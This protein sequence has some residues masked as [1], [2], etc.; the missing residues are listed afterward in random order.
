[1]CCRCEERSPAIWCLSDAVR[2][3]GESVDRDCTVCLEIRRTAVVKD[4]L[5]EARKSKFNPQGMLKVSS[6]SS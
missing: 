1:M 4:A 2:I 5:R 3:L 6:A